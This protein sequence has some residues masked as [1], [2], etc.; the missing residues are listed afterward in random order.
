M[1]SGAIQAASIAAADV[2]SANDAW[3]RDL[4]Q[5]AE[6]LTLGAFRIT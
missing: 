2:T 4:Y 1:Q 5:L 6:S 3:Q